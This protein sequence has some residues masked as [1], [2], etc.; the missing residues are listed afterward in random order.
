MARTFLTLPLEIL[1]TILTD[2][3]AHCDLISLALVSKNIYHQVIPRHSEYRVLRTRHRFPGV[4]AHLA[5]RADLSRN[6]REIHILRK[7]DRAQIEQYPLSLAS[8]VFGKDVTLEEEDLRRWNILTVMGYL[9]RLTVFVWDFCYDHGSLYMDASQE[10]QL[11]RVLSGIPS[12]SRLVLAGD[13]KCLVPQARIKNDLFE[14]CWNMPNLRDLTLMGDIWSSPTIASTLLHVLKQSTQ[15]K[16]LQIPVE[17]TSVCKFVLPSLRQL[18]LFLQSSTTTSLIKQWNVFFENHPLLEDLWCNPS[19][20]MLLPR[21]GLTK[22]KRLSME[23]TFID[24]FKNAKHVPEALECLQYTSFNFAEGVPAR[25]IFR[26]LKKLSLC[27]V[28]SIGWFELDVWL[29]FFSSLP[30]LEV[31][32]GPGIWL[33]VNNDYERMHTAIMNLVQRCPNLRELDHQEHQRQDKNR[34]IVIIKE[35]SKKGLH[36][37]CEIK[38]PRARDYNNFMETAFT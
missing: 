20:T 36:V 31:F 24:S 6:L 18:S 12:L 17:A 4:W 13:L 21:N 34:I 25:S 32:R 28:D 26:N 7:A 14:A 35:Q 10:L 37:R 16:R 8:S 38:R 1:D 5:K 23:R 27:T 3:D 33:S 15:L 11:L 19:S 30:H 9:E 2:V 22:L 29:G